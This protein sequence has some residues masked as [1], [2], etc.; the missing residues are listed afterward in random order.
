MTRDDLRDQIQT[1]LLGG[2]STTALRAAFVAAEANAA[3]DRAH[4]VAAE[5][6]AQIAADAALDAQADGIALSAE[7]DLFDLL[8]S[9]T[10]PVLTEDETHV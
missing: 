5:E 8:A 9:L 4:A 7:T 2:S 3:A 6:A 10:P 1:A